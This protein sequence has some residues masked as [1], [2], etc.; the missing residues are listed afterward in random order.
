M[1]ITTFA[2]LVA[3]AV[4]VFRKREH[5]QM[6]GRRIS[7]DVVATVATLFLLYIGLTL[8]GAMVIS[9]IEELPLL[10]CWYETT[11]AMATVGLTL[12]ITP[13]LSSVSHCILILLMFL[14]RVGGLTLIY[15]AW[16][17]QRQPGKLPLDKIMVG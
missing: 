9:A 14:G 3:C 1:K 12:G 4:S 8:G 10:T 11:S 13:A 16:S 5:A 2:V 15:A 7:H 6:F 17:E